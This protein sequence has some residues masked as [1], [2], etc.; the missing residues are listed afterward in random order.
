MA[1]RE[2]VLFDYVPALMNLI[3]ET[4]KQ[5]GKEAVEKTY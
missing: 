4:M 1:T 2:S 5:G 3:V